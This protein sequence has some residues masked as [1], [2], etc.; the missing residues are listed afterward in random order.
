MS[1][2]RKTQGE[3]GITKARLADLQAAAAEDID[4]SDIPELGNDFW[5]N[6]KIQNRSQ[7]KKAISLRVD[8]DVLAWFKAQG[9]GYSTTMNEVLRHF[10]KAHQ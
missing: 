8:A 5:K 6:A 7:P 10:Y 3:I 2:V 1:T 4:F 9:K